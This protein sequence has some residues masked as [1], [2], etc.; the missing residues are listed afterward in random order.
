MTTQRV[1]SYVVQE[2]TVSYRQLGSDTKL[3]GTP[4]QMIGLPHIP[5]PETLDICQLDNKG[6]TKYILMAPSS[7]GY[8]LQHGVRLPRSRN[9]R[10][11]QYVHY[12]SNIE[13]LAE[14]AAET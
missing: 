5:V 8:K 4:I 6:I 7:G 3:C 2:T 1:L 9:M 11:Q 12:L 14:V 13:P 10:T